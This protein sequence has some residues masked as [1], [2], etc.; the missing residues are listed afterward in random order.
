MKISNRQLPLT[1]I[2]GL[3]G[4]GVIWVVVVI[5]QP[6]SRWVGFGWL[7][8]GLGIFF[9]FRRLK[10]VSADQSG[11]PGGGNTENQK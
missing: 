8:I 4:T 3:L 9:L 7:F 2:L 6:Y 1:A 10:R 11:A 5:M